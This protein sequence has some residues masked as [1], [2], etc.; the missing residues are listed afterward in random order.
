MR[1]I[2][3]VKL[4]LTAKKNPREILEYKD[5]KTNKLDSNFCNGGIMGMNRSCLK[6]LN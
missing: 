3:M 2:N 1:K 6:Y 5:D 4:F